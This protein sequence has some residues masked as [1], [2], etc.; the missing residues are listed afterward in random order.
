MC[1]LCSLTTWKKKNVSR[2]APTEHQ[3]CA[4]MVQGHTPLAHSDKLSVAV[5]L[6]AASR[7]HTQHT[8]V[9]GHLGLGLH[10]WHRLLKPACRQ[11]CIAASRRERHPLN[12]MSGEEV[13]VKPVER[14]RFGGKQNGR[15]LGASDAVV[16]AAGELGSGG[17]GQWS[18]DKVGAEPVSLHSTV[19]HSDM[20]CVTSAH[21]RV[22][23]F[24]HCD[25]WSLHDDLSVS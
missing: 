12:A 7:A 1:A 24:C 14:R 4:R 13:R 15:H 8:P 19:T 23:H 18:A 10:Q 17:H 5:T 6:A 22:A 21:K 9:R 16:A 2:L 11:Q 25:C 3:R 20:A